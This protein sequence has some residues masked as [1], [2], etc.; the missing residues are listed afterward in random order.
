MTPDER[1][2][3]E[4]DHCQAAV[5]DAEVRA[6]R[7][8]MAADMLAPDPRLDA[9]LSGAVV[10]HLSCTEGDWCAAVRLPTRGELP[11]VGH[12]ATIAEAV[13]DALHG[14]ATMQDERA[15]RAIRDAQ[16]WI[17]AGKAVA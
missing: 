1:I 9:A 6:R 7:M 14:L 16:G 2:D 13:A 12:G 3:L 11:R 10:D 4:V 8:R 15:D 5:L 17:R